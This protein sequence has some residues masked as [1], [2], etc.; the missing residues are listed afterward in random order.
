ML[1]LTQ[2]KFGTTEYLTLQTRSRIN[3]CRYKRVRL[4]MDDTRILVNK[5]VKTQYK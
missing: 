3:R 1:W 4:Y 5:H 2:D